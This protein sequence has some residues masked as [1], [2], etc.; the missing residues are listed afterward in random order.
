MPTLEPRVCLIKPLDVPAS[1]LAYCCS[2]EVPL[3]KHPKKLT[4][5]I[6]SAW[7]GTEGKRRYRLEVVHMHIS[8]PIEGCPP[9]AAREAGQCYLHS[10]WSFAQI[11]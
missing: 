2:G 6:S 3:S 7:Q 11:K 5:P 8:H 4:R 10:G 9:L 1:L